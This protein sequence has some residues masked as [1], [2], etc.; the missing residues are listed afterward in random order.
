MKS[1]VLMSMCTMNFLMGFDQIY[2]LEKGKIVEK[3]KPVKLLM[4]NES[5]LH[6]EVEEVAP[7]IIKKLKRK[8]KHLK[9][10]KRPSDN[11]FLSLLN[12][13]NANKKTTKG[14]A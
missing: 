14:K 13:N 6:S 8:T 7:K 12:R 10:D 2:I 1:T 3:G 11:P 5:I 4:D 9:R